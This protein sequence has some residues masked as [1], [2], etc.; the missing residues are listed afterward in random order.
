MR[1]TLLVTSKSSTLGLLEKRYMLIVFTLIF[2]I[3]LLS[4]SPVPEQFIFIDNRPVRLNQ[5]TGG[6]TAT[7]MS[8]KCHETAAEAAVSRSITA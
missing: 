5:L 7:I 4:E 2:T 1:H 3:N 8:T 6:M